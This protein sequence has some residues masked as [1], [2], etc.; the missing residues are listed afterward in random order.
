MEKVEYKIVDRP[1][2]IVVP[3]ESIK[4]QEIVKNVEKPVE[5]VKIVEKEVFVPVEKIVYKDKTVVKVI[6]EQVIQEVEKKVEVPV[7]S[8]KVEIYE[9]IVNK[10]IEKEVFRDVVKK[11]KDGTC[12]SEVNFVTNWNKLMNINFA[13]QNVGDDCITEEAFVDLLVSSLKTNMEKIKLN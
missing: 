8:T 1:I 9:K 2:E 6:R 7:I 12:M 3:S 10:I 5:V 4:L 11:E 13:D